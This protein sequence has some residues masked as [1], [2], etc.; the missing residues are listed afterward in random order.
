VLIAV[1]WLVGFLPA[2]DNVS[3]TAMLLVARVVATA[4]VAA[5]GVTFVLAALRCVGIFG[6]RHPMLSSGRGSGLTPPST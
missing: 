5:G 4:L 1:S 6:R 2:A 3:R